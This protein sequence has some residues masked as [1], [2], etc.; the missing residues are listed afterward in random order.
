MVL[1]AQGTIIYVNHA[2]NG[3]NDGTSWLNAFIDLQDAL[4]HSSNGDSLWIAQGTYYP[5]DTDDRT[6]AFEMR[7]GLAIYG[8]FNGTESSLNQRDW[9]LYPTILS[10][11]VNPNNKSLTVVLIDETVNTLRID[12]ISIQDGDA[13]IFDGDFEGSS[14]NGGG[15]FITSSIP[16]DSLSIFFLNTHIRDNDSEIYGGGIYLNSTNIAHLTLEFYNCILQENKTEL[17]G[18]AM[19]LDIKEVSESDIFF[20]DVLFQDNLSFNSIA[21]AIRY[22]NKNLNANLSF[23][24]CS[25]LSN[26]GGVGY[27]ALQLSSC[28]AL[29]ISIDQCIFDDNS[30]G[31]GFEKGYGGIGYIAN[32]GDIFISNSIFSNNFATYNGTLSLN[33]EQSIYFINCIFRQN[34]AIRYSAIGSITGNASIINSTFVGNST[35]FIGGTNQ[36]GLFSLSDESTLS[37]Y[38]SICWNNNLGPIFT[39]NNFDSEM[40]VFYSL[41]QD[42]ICPENTF[43]SEV[44]YQQDPLF[45]DLQNNDFS[46][47]MCSPALNAGDNSIIDS[48]NILFDIDSFSRII[49]NIVDMGAYESEAM[50]T[51][52]TEATSCFGS[53]NGF[54]YF[55][56]PNANPPFSYYWETENT[57]GTTIDFLYADTYAVTVTDSDDCSFQTTFVIQEPDSFFIGYEL[58]HVSDIAS[59]DG[60]IHITSIEGGTAPYSYQWSTGDIDLQINNLAPDTYTLLITDSQNCTYQYIFEI[61]FISKNVE[62]QDNDIRLYPNPV[63]QFVELNTRKLFPEDTHWV[64]YNHLGQEVDKRILSSTET[65]H[66]VFLNPIPSGIYWYQ[67]TS[68]HKIFTKGKLLIVD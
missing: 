4:E 33:S 7:D 1:F 15:V 18:G 38:N 13:D 19:Y 35:T 47:L 8:G 44:T 25:F 26:Y 49:D 37:I 10:G 40:N 58:E 31:G 39:P 62:I 48:L 42:T 14:V 51:V 16:K 17:E 12:G 22:E 68:G 21:G 5:T 41:L 57:S 43:C 59:P 50:I 63:Q 66:N 55:D 54:V 27:G 20:N 45:T 52:F 61:D 56:I 30:S 67:I 64:L 29:P 28:S 11:N 3:L 53:Q 2:A 36:G 65:K 9:E 60:S 46:L 23:E 6:I 34:H 32:D 24:D